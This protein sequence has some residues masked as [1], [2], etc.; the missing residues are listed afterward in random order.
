MNR[1]VLIATIGM[2]FGII[3]GLYLKTNITFF[4]CAVILLLVVL[5]IQRKKGYLKIL[6]K[7]NL[8]VVFIISTLIS[9]LYIHFKDYKYSLI[10][11]EENILLKGEI[12]SS[13]KKNTYTDEY[14]INI[15]DYNGI[16]DIS[17]ILYIK[18]KNGAKEFEYGDVIELTCNIEIADDKRNY[19]GFSQINYYKSKGIYGNLYSQSSNVKL[20]RKNKVSIGKIG[21]SIKNAIKNNILKSL[22]KET[23]GIL[24]GML[25]GDKD[26]LS[27]EKKEQFQKSSLIHILCVSR[28]TCWIINYMDSENL[29]RVRKN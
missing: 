25:V 20:I 22:S 9:C 7:N 10:K 24:L 12:K 1:P 3:W 14:L 17:F 15:Q 27:D 19:E 23:A 18:R 8:I 11:P 16:S 26:E 2:L 13:V 21:N 5:I 29:I 28:S 4:F 6:L